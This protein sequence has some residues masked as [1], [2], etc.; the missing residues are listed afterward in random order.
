MARA[1][2]SRAQMALAFETTYGT[3]PASG[4][5]RMPFATSSLSSERP[6]LDNE[7]LGYGRDPLAPSLD[8]LVS[9]GDVA[10]PVDAIGIGHWLKSLLG[11]PTTTGTDPYS[12]SFVSGGFTL[13]SMSIEIGHPEVPIFDMFSGVVVD[14]M[15]FSLARSGQLQAVAKLI[16]QGNAAASTSHAGTLADIA[17]QRFTHFN[18]SIKRDGSA[19]G[20]IVSA[21]FTYANNLDR[22]EVIRNDGKIDG[23]DPGMASLGGSIVARFANTTLLD[24]ATAADPCELE[25][26]WTISADVSLTLTAHAVYLPIPRRSVDGPGGVQVTFDWQAAKA[27]SPVRMFTVVLVNDKASY[28]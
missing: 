15:K 28:A 5:T 14:S 3:A 26:A 2:G 17:L 13:P 9:D 20:N 18:A 19:I 8:V 7:L 21:D 23:V 16:A 10:V 22:I 12:H 27:A 1:Q 25:F 11:A 6:L 24:Q 4:F